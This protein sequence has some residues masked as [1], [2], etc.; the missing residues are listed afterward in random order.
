MD[1]FAIAEISLS[2]GSGDVG[3]RTPGPEHL[4]SAGVQA[5]P[6]RSALGTLLPSVRQC[7]SGG[8]A[9]TP[10]PRRRTSSPCPASPPT[11]RLTAHKVPRS[12]AHA[13]LQKLGGGFCPMVVRFP[14]KS[15]RS[16]PEPSPARRLFMLLRSSTCVFMTDRIIDKD[17]PEKAV[18]TPRAVI[19][20]EGGRAQGSN[21][22]FDCVTA[23]LWKVQKCSRSTH[24]CQSGGCAIPRQRREEAQQPSESRL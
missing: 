13:V 11:R 12:G 8:G 5:R 19:Q 4:P 9:V 20:L 16:F 22:C 17:S 18:S 10:R 3:H 7:G 1:I 24:A 14:A 2:T 21:A 6:C 23:G 15:P